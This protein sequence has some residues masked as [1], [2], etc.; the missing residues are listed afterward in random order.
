MSTPVIHKGYPQ[1]VRL[2]RRA[3]FRLHEQHPGAVVVSRPSKFGNP[4]TVADA[5]EA[6][7]ATTA[8]EAR[9]VCAR[10][11]RLWLEDHVD[12]AWLIS[13]PMLIVRRAW[14][15]ERL[16]DLTGRPLSC[17]CPLPPPGEVDHCHAAVL[18]EFANQGGN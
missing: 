16:T 1:R 8:A 10:F 4:F 12:G 9:E 14:I 17:W 13:N 2:S 3:G 7:M 6:G 11:F 18:I 15:L 5:L